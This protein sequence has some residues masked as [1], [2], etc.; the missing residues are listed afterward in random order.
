MAITTRGN[1]PTFAD[2]PLWGNAST[3]IT[4][5]IA[6]LLNDGYATQTQPGSANWN[7]ITNYVSAGVLHCFIYGIP[8]WDTDETYVAGSYL[9]RN[10]IIFKSRVGANTGNIPESSPTQWQDT[11]L[12]LPFAIAGSG[13]QT[14]QNEFNEILNIDTTGGDIALTID[15]GLF[16]NQFI[17]IVST[18]GNKT[19]LTIS[20]LSGTV[21]LDDQDLLITWDGSK[22]FVS[23]DITSKKVVAAS[24]AIV[25][26][27]VS[28]STELDTGGG[29]V[30]LDPL[31][32]PD[33]LGQRIDFVVSGSGDGTITAGTGIVFDQVITSAEGI[34]VIAVDKSGTLT[35]E[36]VIGRKR[37]CKAWVNFDG[38]GVV[39]I[40]DSFNVSSIIDNGVGDYTINFTNALNSSNITISGTAGN[41]GVPGSEAML[42]PNV[43]STTSV[44]MGTEN[45]SGVAVDRDYV[46]IIF[47][48]K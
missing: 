26:G 14:P 29:N 47:Y 37:V 25:F 12:P 5:P 20:G 38:T 48:A 1:K 10:G 34:S 6:S 27:P 35:W 36:L 8:I 24:G 4:K 32:T 18:G 40:Q 23:Q 33:F 42:F 3:N 22:Y 43:V 41:I 31:P 46:S 17:K 44:S 45:S 2:S 7:W 13:T 39:A 21:I 11:R 16:V 28:W 9:N 30:I 15:P 19:T